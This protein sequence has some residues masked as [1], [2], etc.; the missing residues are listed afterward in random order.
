MDAEESDKVKT[1]YTDG[2][3]DA[4]VDRSVAYGVSYLES[5]DVF[6]KD[7]IVVFDVDDTALS[8]FCFL[9]R[10]AFQ[11]FPCFH[12]DY[13]NANVHTPVAL[14]SVLK[15]YHY[16]KHRGLQ[17]VF[18]SER[19]EQARMV[20]TQSLVA[21]GFV[22]P[23]D[24]IILRPNNRCMESI[25]VFKARERQALFEKEGL[26]IVAVV[27]D[28]MSDFYDGHTGYQ[29]KLPNYLYHIK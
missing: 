9:A 14:P 13:I 5:I 12:P 19:S 4:Q 8:S 11:P 6:R 2:T 1:V 3:V 28:Q 25:S 23:K 24:R 27:G 20:T 22:G 7:Q 21:A 15:L 16:M 18:L 29:I 26:E 17:V 10:N